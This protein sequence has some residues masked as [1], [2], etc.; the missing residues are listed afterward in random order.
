MAP[1]YLGGCLHALVARKSGSDA[2]DE[3]NP[4]ILAASGIVAGEGLAGVLVAALVGLKWAP[5]EMSP[6]LAGDVGLLAGAGL[7]LLVS[8][9]LIRAGRRVQA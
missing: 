9:F 7:L 5:K 1:V 6:R 4:G 3:S 2:T 8:A